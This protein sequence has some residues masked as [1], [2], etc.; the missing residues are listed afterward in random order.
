MFLTPDVDKE[1][2]QELCPLANLILSPENLVIKNIDGKK[3]S[4]Q[5]LLNFIHACNETFKSG[6]LPEVTTM[7]EVYL[8][9]TQIR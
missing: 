1:F 3:A 7:L 5:L 9:Q 4:P 6:K 2:V 8:H